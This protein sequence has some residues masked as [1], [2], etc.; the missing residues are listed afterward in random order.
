MLCEYQD[1]K[2]SSS[3]QHLVHKRKSKPF[4]KI[5]YRYGDTLAR[6]LLDRVSATLFWITLMTL[7]HRRWITP[8]FAAR[9]VK[10]MPPFQN[11]NVN[12]NCYKF[13]SAH[14]RGVEKELIHENKIVEWLAGKQTEKIW[15]YFNDYELA[16]ETSFGF[17]A[18]HSFTQTELIVKGLLRQCLSLNCVTFS[19]TVLPNTSILAK[20]WILSEVGRKILRKELELPYELPDPMEVASKLLR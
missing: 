6:P 15:R 19:L 2:N 3:G 7:L 11:K 18:A 9:A 5:T 17:F 14:Q 20:N 12:Y 1:I 4:M 13:W 8:N 10:S 16:E